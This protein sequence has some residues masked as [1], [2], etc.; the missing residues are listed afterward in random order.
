M[1]NNNIIFFGTI[2]AH[3]YIHDIHT[4][5]NVAFIDKYCKIRL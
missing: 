5:L 2:Y 1:I 4:A 3:T